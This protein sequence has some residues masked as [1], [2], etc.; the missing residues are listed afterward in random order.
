MPLALLVER[1]RA[2]ARGVALVA[3]PLERRRHAGNT[4]AL[5]A[6][7][8]KRR[9]HRPPL[10][11]RAEV[12]QRHQE[13]GRE[14]VRLRFQFARSRVALVQVPFRAFKR[15]LQRAVQH[16]VPEFMGHGE[17]YPS[18]RAMRRAVTDAPAAAIGV[19]RQT[20]FDTRHI[21]FLD[22]V[23]VRLRKAHPAVFQGELLHVDGESVRSEHAR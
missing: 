19:R 11:L 7:L 21:D 22:T 14:R 5:A 16:E 4:V 18:W 10:Q 20:A 6:V 13:I 15:S 3:H 23:H 2:P 17:A 8:Q 1:H 12:V 9:P